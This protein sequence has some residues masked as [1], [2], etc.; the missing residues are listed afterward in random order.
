MLKRFLELPSALR[1]HDAIAALEERDPRSPIIEVRFKV[2]L[3]SIYSHRHRTSTM[4]VTQEKLPASQVRLDIEIPSETSKQ[5]YEKIVQR[6]AKSVSLPGFRKGKAPRN[7][8]LQRLGPQRVKAEA[9][10]EL[11]QDNL[12]R[13]IKSESIDAIGNYN[14]VSSFDDLLARF[15]PGEP[16]I[17]SASVDV[18]PEVELGE[19]R[20]LKVTAEKTE[21][22][23]QQVE[24][25]IQRQQD[26]HATLVPVEG[27]PV[28]MGDMAVVDYAGRLADADEEAEPIE[29][30]E[31]TNFQMEIDEGKFVSGLIEG[32]VGMNLEETK[33]I[34]VTFPEDYP[35]EALA[36]KE[37]VFEVTV[38]ELKE[39]ELPELDDEFAEEVSEF[40]TMA[41]LRES[42]ES[43]YRESADRETQNS[44]EAA[45]VAELV[46]DAK[47]DPPATKI[48]RELDTLLTQTAMQMQQYGMQLDQLFT[49]ENLPQLR[50]RSRPEA[51]E[52]LRQSLAL[53]EVAKRE[54]LEP[55]EEAIA[56]KEKELLEELS[57]K[58]VDPERLRSFVIEDLSKDNALKW[59]QEQGSVELV[60]KGSL[61]K[62][63][64]EGEEG[65]EGEEEPALDA[66][67]ATVE[68]EAEEV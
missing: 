25:L 67:E 42:L 32:I 9:L 15:T 59:L 43:Q 13:A 16:F 19:Y 14:L 41:E 64:E 68:V 50:E 61:D 63:E 58:D 5:V 11:I 57:D 38:K 18:P 23:P 20:G 29:G 2:L 44:I 24:E 1:T 55:D 28:Q 10:E 30:I 3:F 4:K 46:K 8:L 40:E 45:L 36:G 7:I 66:S 62:D 6:L 39:K 21:Y 53:L 12:E 65:E 31:A 34:P 52:R 33:H 37:V 26:A 51:I 54:S 22:D 17:F 35:Q 49:K 27:R 60:P 47:I 48:E 56:A